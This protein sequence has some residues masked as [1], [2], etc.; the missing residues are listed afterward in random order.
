LLYDKHKSTIPS[1][2]SCRHKS[3]VP[4][5]RRAWSPLNW[6]PHVLTNNSAFSI[7]FYRFSLSLCIGNRDNRV[8]L[9]FSFFKNTP[10]IPDC[11]F[12]Y[13]SILFTSPL[14]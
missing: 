13:D 4:L 5:Y 10:F 9:L 1:C 3:K 2:F 12:F 14:E 11:H 6:R 8:W 7:F